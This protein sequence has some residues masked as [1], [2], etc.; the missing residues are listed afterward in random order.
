M[1]LKIRIIS[2]G[3]KECVLYRNVVVVQ[4]VGDFREQ[5]LR[6]VLACLDV[7]LGEPFPYLGVKLFCGRVDHATYLVD[8]LRKEPKMPVR[9]EVMRLT[10]GDIITE[11]AGKKKSYVLLWSSQPK[12]YGRG[13]IVIDGCTR[14]TSAS[15]STTGW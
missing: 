13:L 14:N 5:L 11:I 10:M 7:Y 2:V 8:V 12:D 15:A 1:S 6:L 9:L 3:V 4:Y